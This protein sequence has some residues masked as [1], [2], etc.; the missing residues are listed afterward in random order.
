MIIT[1]LTC[2]KANERFETAAY[3]AGL[4]GEDFKVL[5]MPRSIALA[6]G[7]AA[8]LPESLAIAQNMND[9]AAR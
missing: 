6:S 9:R 2:S 5:A 1:V 3:A 7:T 4:S 8:A